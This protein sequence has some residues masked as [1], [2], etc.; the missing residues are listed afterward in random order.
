MNLESERFE[1]SSPDVVPEYASLES[2]SIAED[3]P[4]ASLRRVIAGGLCLPSGGIAALCRLDV[5]GVIPRYE[6]EQLARLLLLFNQ[7]PYALA[8]IPVATLREWEEC[9]NRART[10]PCRR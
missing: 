5:A 2:E 3:E 1:R 8:D 4:T 9:A 10:P 6:S 7:D